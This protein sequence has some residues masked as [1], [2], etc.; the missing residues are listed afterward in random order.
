[1]K[2][3]HRAQF[4]PGLATGLAA[5]FLG[6]LLLAAA[7]AAQIPGGQDPKSKMLNQNPTA[8]RL[9]MVKH[10]DAIDKRLA[11]LEAIQTKM[12]QHLA[13]MASR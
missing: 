6:A 13:K 1:M 11:K 4:V 5:G 8:Q 3:Q 10:L 7:P 9:T 12:E 2:R